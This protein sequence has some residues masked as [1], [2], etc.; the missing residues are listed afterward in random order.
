M[1]L[2]QNSLTGKKMKIIIGL[3]NPGQDYAR[4]RHN[5]GFEALDRLA[6]KLNMDF[7]R[8]KFSSLVAEGFYQGEKILLVK[9]TTFMNLSGNAVQQILTFYKEE[10]SNILVIYDDIDLDVGQLRIR[11]NGGPGSHNGMKDI[12]SKI[13]SRD[14]PRIRLGIGQ[15]PRIPLASYVLSRFGPDE[16][17]PMEEAIDLAAQAAKA[18][19]DQDLDTA[20]NKFNRRS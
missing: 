10:A 14:F 16:E 1:N 11:K 17:G 5:V 18:I 13:G 8:A 6:D 2:Y 20:M 15:D 12:I 4:T 19:L 3:G 9:P 7:N